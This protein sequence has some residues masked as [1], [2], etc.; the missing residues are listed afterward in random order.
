MIQIIKVNENGRKATVQL[1]ERARVD[2]ILTAVFQP[3][4]QSSSASCDVN[5]HFKKNSRYRARFQASYVHLDNA[6]WPGKEAGIPLLL[7]I[8]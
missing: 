2:F 8:F 7:N 6:N 1:T 4:F 3:R 5:L